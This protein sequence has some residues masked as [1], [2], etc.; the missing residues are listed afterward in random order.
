[1]VTSVDVSVSATLK[2]LGINLDL[3]RL[4]VVSVTTDKISVRI[5]RDVVYYVTTTKTAVAGMDFNDVAKNGVTVRNFILFR[6]SLL[7]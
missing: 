2:V 7:C 6:L 3:M 1:M 4:A 5:V